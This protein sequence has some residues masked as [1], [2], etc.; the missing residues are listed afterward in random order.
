MIVI[1]F[2]G[3]DVSYFYEEQYEYASDE[4]EEEMGVYHNEQN[5]A[6]S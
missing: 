4:I 6:F 3:L 1:F 2:K 5:Q